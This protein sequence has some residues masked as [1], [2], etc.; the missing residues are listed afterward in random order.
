MS[1]FRSEICVCVTPPF[2][3]MSKALISILSVKRNLSLLQ[4]E[5]H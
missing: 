1:L 4:G 5:A 2:P 3:Y